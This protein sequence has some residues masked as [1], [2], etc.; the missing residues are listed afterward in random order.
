MWEP[1]NN[2][3]APLLI[4]KYHETHLLKDKRMAKQARVASSLPTSHFPQPTWLIT[5]DPPSILDK[6][7]RPAVTC[8]AAVAAATT[9]ATTAPKPPPS[10][11]R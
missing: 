9:A 2:I 1:V 7:E 3:Q 10:T 4:R 8:P 11:P 6:S 5:D